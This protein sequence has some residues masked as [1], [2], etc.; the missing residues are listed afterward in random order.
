[1]KINRHILKIR[2]K[3]NAPNSSYFDGDSVEFTIGDSLSNEAENNV[4]VD[5]EF[6]KYLRILVTLVPIK[7]FN[8]SARATVRY[9]P[10]VE[11]D[12]ESVMNF[13]IYE[14]PKFPMEN[15]ISEIDIIYKEI[16]DVNSDITN[17]KEQLSSKKILYSKK[18]ITENSSK[19][20]ETMALDH[21][22]DPDEYNY[23]VSRCYGFGGIYHKGIAVSDIE[24]Y[25]YHLG[26]GLQSEEYMDRMSSR[27]LLA[28]K[29]TKLSDSINLSD[30]TSLE[31]DVN[32]GKILI[33]LEDSHAI[34]ESFQIKK[35]TIIS[36]DC[37]IAF[38]LKN[39][40][41]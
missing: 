3:R 1:M 38:R 22:L 4:F 9:K 37:V 14:N 17:L 26:T 40:K 39:S 13:P 12:E 33:S 6:P 15:F 19:T 25:F 41:A 32:M 29:Y 21:R 20:L 10:I 2:P 35:D 18:F 24:Q 31:D 5:I 28:C 8:K 23:Y 27:K 30:I 11:S 16:L 36:D 34:Y 7:N